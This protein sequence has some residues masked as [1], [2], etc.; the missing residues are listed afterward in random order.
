MIWGVY[1]LKP[2]LLASLIFATWQQTTT[3]KNVFLLALV[4]SFLGDVCLMWNEQ[5]MFLLGL[6]CFLS[7]HLLYSWVFSK[8]AS[9]R[10]IVGVLFILSVGFFYFSVLHKNLPAELLI[11]IVVYMLVITFMGITLNS[12]NI[13]KKSAGFG[14]GIGA[15]LFLISDSLIA[16]NEFITPIPYPTLLIMST[17]GVAQYLITNGYWEIFGKTHSPNIGPNL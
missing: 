5:L 11:P 8:K 14:V 17:Y 15:I 2:L 13:A 12:L 16:A 4:G 6:S 1:I 10:F 3:Y 9:Y 7:T